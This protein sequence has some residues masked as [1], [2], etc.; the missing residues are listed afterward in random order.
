MRRSLRATI[1]HCRRLTGDDAMRA[2]E[3]LGRAVGI[4]Q[5]EGRTLAVMGGFLLLSTANTT[6]MSAVN[7]E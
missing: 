5:G 3:R 4:R 2:S 6:V 1:P 7:E